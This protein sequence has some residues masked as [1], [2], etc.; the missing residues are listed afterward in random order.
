MSEAKKPKKKK[1]IGGRPPKY[2]KVDDLQKRIDWYFLAIE[3]NNGSEDVV[4]DPEFLEATK[5]ITDV[6]PTVTGL[7]LALNMTRE[8]LVHYA[9]KDGFADTIKKAKLRIENA[10]E[11]RLFYQNATGSIFNLKNNFG[12]HDKSEKELSGSLGL[13]RILDEIDGQSTDPPEA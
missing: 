12:W 7:A 10:I 6:I 8:G 11:Q 1:N 2:K 3:R 5:I 13:S 4:Y 9:A